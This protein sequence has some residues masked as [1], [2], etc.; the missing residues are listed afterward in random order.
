[1]RDDRPRDKLGEERDKASV[2][3]NRA[4]FNLAVKGIN[5]ER[6]LL[7]REKAYA[8][9]EHDVFK[10]PAR[11]ENGVHRVGKEIVILKVKEYAEVESDGEGFGRLALFIAREHARELIKAKVYKHAGDN[12]D[13]I[14]RRVRPVKPQRHSKQKNER[15]AVLLE[16]IQKEIPRKTQRQKAQNKYI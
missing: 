7:E 4:I 14:L 16:L 6:E 15:Q 10:R 13:K 8:E 9:R 2:V 11:A 1:M 3:Q 12:E 5:D